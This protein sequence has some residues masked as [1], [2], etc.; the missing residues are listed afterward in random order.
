V[1]F[2]D[3]PTTGL[4]ATSAYHVVRTLKDLAERGRTVVMTIHQPRSEMWHLFDNIVLLSQGSCVYSGDTASCVAYFVGLGYVLPPFVNPSEFLIDLAAVDSRSAELEKASLERVGT[5][6]RAWK[7]HE[8]SQ[9]TAASETEKKVPLP[10]PPP[11]NPASPV[12]VAVSRNPKVSTWRQFTI[13]TKRAAVVSIRD[14]M[15]VLATFAQSVIIALTMGVIFYKLDGSLRGIR[16]R[17]GAFY[18]AVALQ[19]YQI[20]IYECYRLSHEMELFDRERNEGVVNVVA[21]LASRR[22]AKL[23]EDIAVSFGQHV[24]LCVLL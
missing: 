12:A 23:V 17:S 2:A 16:S 13:L 22:A 19:G 15:G 4:D 21:F 3:E 14:P 11:P 9:L 5:L 8:S 6:K 10:P 1:L 18:S 24:V 7:A 20:L